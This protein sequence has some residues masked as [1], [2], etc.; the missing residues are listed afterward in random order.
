MASN[1]VNVFKKV[2][3]FSCGR[4]APLLGVGI[5]H[6]RQ[7]SFTLRVKVSAINLDP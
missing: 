3:G 2:A 4:K 7:V 6:M 5:G 1:A